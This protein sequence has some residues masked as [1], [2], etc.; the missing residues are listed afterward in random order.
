MEQK[1][2]LVV[3]ERHTDEGSW[4]VILGIYDDFGKALERVDEIFYESEESYIENYG[5]VENFVAENHHNGFAE[6]HLDDGWDETIIRATEY[7]INKPT[8]DFFD[9]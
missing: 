8:C 9:L 2:W 3:N 4:Q 7:E 6:L 5:G 1:I